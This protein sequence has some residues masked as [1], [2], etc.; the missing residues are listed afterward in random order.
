MFSE[1]SIQ[2][3]QTEYFRT[4][5]FQFWMCHIKERHSHVDEVEP[6]QG[7]RETRNNGSVALGVVVQL[8]EGGGHQL[9]V[10]GH[11]EVGFLLQLHQEQLPVLFRL[12]DVGRNVGVL[13]RL[14]VGPPPVANCVLNGPVCGW[15]TIGSPQGV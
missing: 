9:V 8:E 12:G 1:Y 6:S 15:R 13:S 3:L 4:I 5:V 10:P 7:L 11:S 2:N 14:K